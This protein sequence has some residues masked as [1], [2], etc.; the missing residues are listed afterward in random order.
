M[1]HTANLS[2]L[3]IGIGSDLSWK[4]CRCDFVD[5]N[6][7]FIDCPLAKELWSEIKSWWHYLGC[8][9]AISM[10]LLLCKAH[11]GRPSFL[12]KVHEAI[13]LLY[14]WVLWSFRNDRVFKNVV[15]SSSVLVFEVQLLSYMWINASKRK[16]SKLHWLE[17][18]SN[19]VLEFKEHFVVKI[20]V[21]SFVFFILWVVFLFVVV[22]PSFLASC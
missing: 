16:G 7:V 5:D 21:I 8:L 13:C 19:P 4:T 9:P 17:W 18:L 12:L 14:I 6:H 3:D 10:E 22:S 11:F 15:K 1:A 2:S 20:V